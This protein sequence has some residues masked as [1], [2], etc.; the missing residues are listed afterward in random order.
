MA[1]SDNPPNLQSVCMVSGATCYRAAC[2][3]CE[4]DLSYFIQAQALRGQ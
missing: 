3:P 1:A 4:R 2:R